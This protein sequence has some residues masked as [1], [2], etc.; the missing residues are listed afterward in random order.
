MLPDNIFILENGDYTIINQIAL[1]TSLLIELRTKEGRV[2]FYS[3]MLNV[4]KNPDDYSFPVSNHLIGFCTAIYFVIDKRYKI[5]FIPSSVCYALLVV[6]LPELF[7][8]APRVR[9]VRSPFLLEKYTRAKE[10]VTKF[11]H[12]GF[13][14]KTNKRRIQILELIS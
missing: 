3:E 11:T 6:F 10:K 2:K 12:Y 4:Y 8:F 13:W 7:H 5:D 1:P 14:F 9:Y